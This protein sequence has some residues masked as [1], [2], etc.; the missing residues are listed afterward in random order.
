MSGPVGPGDAIIRLRR[1]RQEWLDCH[2][3]LESGQSIRRFPTWP[4]HE[5]RWWRST[6]SAR[7]IWGCRVRCSAKRP[8]RKRRRSS[9]A[10]APPSPANCAP[11]RVSASWRGTA[12]ARWPG[13]TSWWCRRGVTRARRRRR[14]CWPRCGGRMRAAR[15]WSACAWAPSCWP[16]PACWTAAAPPRTGAGLRALRNATRGCS[17]IPMSCTWTKATC[18][19]RPAPPPASTAACTCCAA[20]SARKRQTA[21][22]APWWC[23][24]TGRAAR[25]N[26]SSS[27]CWRPR[28]TRR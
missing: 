1:F 9:C 21:W 6:G 19:P 10:Y 8:T 7:S 23:R 11:R 5:W 18:S 25:R 12:C 16:R 24:R 27:R 3:W 13:P 26:T 2:S 4:G 17:S 22:R 28:A 15:W 20:A 14:R